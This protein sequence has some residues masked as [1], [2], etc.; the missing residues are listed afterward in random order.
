M[1]ESRKTRYTRQVLR[2]A[3][4]DALQTE[5]LAAIT[6]TEL[7]RRADLNRGTFY[8]HYAS[9]AELLEGWKQSFSPLSSPA[10][11][12]PTS[13]TTTSSACPSFKS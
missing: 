3:L 10:G 5:P 7:C 13:S 6:V 11:K 1:Q 2:E 12:T 4:I 8:L 9:P